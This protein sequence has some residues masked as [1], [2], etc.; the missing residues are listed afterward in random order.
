[1]YLYNTQSNSDWLFNTW[2]IVLQADW[3]ILENNERATLNID[4]P[5]CAKDGI[6]PGTVSVTTSA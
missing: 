2:P 6:L 4:T 1:M 3:M 5:H